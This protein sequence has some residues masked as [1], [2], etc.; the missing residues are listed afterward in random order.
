MIALGG[1]SAAESVTDGLYAY[2]NFTEDYN[3][4]VVDI[5]NGHNATNGGTALYI[6]GD[7]GSFRT[8]NGVDNIVNIS[9]CPQP[10]VGWAGLSYHT[11][12]NASNLTGYVGLVA[13]GL[14]RNMFYIA[15]GKPVF[16]IY[17]N[18][19]NTITGNHTA[20]LNVGCDIIVTYNNSSKKTRMY[21]NGELIGMG[22]VNTEPWSVIVP[23]RGIG[24][25]T[26]TNGTNAYF[27]G[28]MY[29]WKT[30]DRELN[31]SEV[32]AEVAAEAWRGNGTTGDGY[33]PSPSIR[34]PKLTNALDYLN[35][36]TYDGSGQQVHPSIAH[37]E[38][39]W[40]GY[41]YIGAYCAYPQGDD[42]LEAVG[43]RGSNNGINWSQFTGCPDPVVP[44]P[45]N[46]SWVI[47]DENILLH[48]GTLEVFY[49]YSLSTDGSQAYTYFVNSTNAVNWSEPTL[50]DLPA[51]LSP[52]VLLENGVWKLW[53]V[54]SIDHY[55]RHF[56]STNQ[57]NWTEIPV[58]LSVPNREFLWH[59]EVRNDTGQQY[60]MLLDVKGTI[61]ELWYLKSYD[62]LM[63]SCPSDDNPVL[64]NNTTGTW[65]GYLIYKSAFMY[66]NNSYHVWYSASD[67]Y[68]VAGDW[69]VGYA[70]DASKLP[71]YTEPLTYVA[72][73]LNGTLP[74]TMTVTG[75]YLMNVTMLNAGTATWT[76]E[77]VYLLAY[78]D[79]GLFGDTVYN[80]TGNVTPGDIVSFL[81][82]I[83][84]PEPGSYTY[85]ATMRQRDVS[86]IAEGITGT[87]TVE[88]LDLWMPTAT[89]TANNTNGYTPLAVQFN[90]TG[91]N[92]T[93]FQWSFDDGT[94]NET[95]EN[96]T[97]T[98]TVPDSYSVILTATNNNGSASTTRT[99]TVS[100]IPVIAGFTADTTSGVEP[101][102]VT[103]T[104]SSVNATSWL[105][106]FGDG[107]TSTSQ[108]P[109]HEYT[110]GT[111]TIT[112]TAY[113]LPYSQD[114]E[115]KTS[116]ITVTVAP[117]VITDFT[118]TPTSGNAPLSVSFSVSSTGLI[119][120][121]SWDFGD[122][123]FTSD[124]NPSHTYLF[125]GTYTVQ[126]TV[127]NSGGS[128]TMT[129][130]GYISVYG[131]G[132]PAPGTV[133][134]VPTIPAPDYN[135]WIG[136]TIPPDQASLT[137][138]NPGYDQTLAA[139]GINSSSPQDAD[140]NQF[141]GPA[142][143]GG[144]TTMFAAAGPIIA[145]IFGLVIAYIFFV[146]YDGSLFIPGLV[147]MATGAISGGIAYSIGWPAEALMFCV[148]CIIMGVA[149]ALFEA[150]VS[151]S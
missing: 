81:F 114:T 26:F 67:V 2:Y 46:L 10:L 146:K 31:E 99:I 77:D 143:I 137:I 74:S 59:L 58:A 140:L 69:H 147:L 32:A 85:N 17:T 105:W 54:D 45:A 109:S 148:A 11:R 75:T 16:S 19:L 20:T 138:S 94:A 129:K 8:Y 104:D 38:T 51:I 78:G 108:N 29:F 76:P 55:V 119:Q 36:T 3:L 72:T 131:V 151:R 34:V 41:T 128:D 13:Q 82:N 91:S 97:H 28:I 130:T 117:P 35:I 62:G 56:T 123:K 21:L 115:T 107:D 132:N 6:G 70:G 52:S 24:R 110:A 101:L 113:N 49:R 79:A 12:I 121:Y 53:G 40:N 141:D 57:V 86:N 145:I 139:L 1:I 37:N 127:S 144:L 63:W 118:G 88:A 5:A 22:N 120:S 60:D 43:I 73:V 9:L 135:K 18:G 50:T 80:L 61:Y 23:Q 98:F 149:G 90:F 7:N 100:A 15:D 87:I 64:V 125:P 83:T 93:S 150:I 112:L 39:P 134:P 44:A 14:G 65:D 84:A 122:Y 96:C 92:S 102:T 4:T 95:T 116:Y 142:I 136:A 68:G 47:S 27:P 111:Y 48:N 133:N 106:N 42:N 30:Y 25:T 124:Q 66:L 126:L 71:V 103:F 33:V 89:M